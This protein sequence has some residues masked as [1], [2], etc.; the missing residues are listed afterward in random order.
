METLVWALIVLIIV[1]II[2]ILMLAA[3]LTA[4]TLWLMDYKKQVRGGANRKVAV[5][6][7]FSNLKMNKLQKHIRDWAAEFGK[8]ATSKRKKNSGG[9]L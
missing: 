9:E 3:F 5:R 6:P 7:P 1:L 2:T 4:A 8:Q